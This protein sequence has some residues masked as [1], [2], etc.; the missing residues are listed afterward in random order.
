MTKGLYQH[1]RNTWKKEKTDA[2]IFLRSS[3]IKWRKES[4]FKKIDR[5]TKLNKARGLGYRAKKGFIVIRARIGRGGRRR[6]KYGRGGRKPSKTGLVNYTTEKS[7]R[8]IAEQRVQKK[9]PNLEVI[10]SYYLSEDG[11][12]KW[13]E[14]ILVDPNSPEIKKDKN[15]KW[16]VEKQHRRRVL[17]GLP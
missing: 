15:M 3:M 11:I 17:R 1:I 13:F 2:M 10:G 5:P 6:P 4:R 7:L 8:K 14:I 9:Y 16:V 12:S